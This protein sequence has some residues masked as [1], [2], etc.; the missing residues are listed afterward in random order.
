MRFS[1]LLALSLLPAPAL[2]EV[3]SIDPVHTRVMVA[4]EH[5]GFSRALGTVSG[6]SGRIAFEAGW[7]DAHVDVAIPLDRLDFGDAGWNRAVQRLLDTSR[8]PGARFVSDRVTPRDATHAEICGTLT[9]HGVARPLCMDATLN[10]LE[11]HPMPP[12]RRTLGI[13]ATTRLDRF[14][15]AID[16]WPTVIGRDVEIRIELEASRGIGAPKPELPTDE[17]TAR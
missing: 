11:R 13:S 4:V 9:L 10:A 17:D 6:S 16:A 1:L 5:A 8:T 15:Y 12:F 7:K 14:D 3:F 2:A